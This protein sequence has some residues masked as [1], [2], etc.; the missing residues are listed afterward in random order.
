[1]DRY[2]L[3]REIEKA[4]LSKNKTELYKNIKPEDI[5]S[6]IDILWEYIDE[7]DDAIVAKRELQ[8]LQNKIKSL[9][10][11]QYSIL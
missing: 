5:R 6:T 7:A 11:F 2:L 1:M 4:Y 8:E 3:R 9:N 10:D